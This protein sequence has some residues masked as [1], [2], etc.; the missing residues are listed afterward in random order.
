VEKFHS[1]LTME[2]FSKSYFALNRSLS[3][4]I[5]I[6][7]KRTEAG[8]LPSL[9]L[10][11]NKGGVTLS[12]NQF[13]SLILEEPRIM[14]YLDS[15]S[16]KLDYTLSTPE[17]PL[18]VSGSA[19]KCRFIVLRQQRGH[20]LNV[21]NMAKVTYQRLIDMSSLI[22]RYMVRLEKAAPTCQE[23]YVKCQKGELCP[24]LHDKI[25]EQGFDFCEFAMELLLFENGVKDDMSKV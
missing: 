7:L 5:V 17:N 2:L 20:I 18:T 11:D 23:M 24:S 16:A 14:D 8:F 9:V 21:L 13:A 22:Q 12:L 1:R 4:N 15:R 6:C 19:G 25:S 3:K 10:Y